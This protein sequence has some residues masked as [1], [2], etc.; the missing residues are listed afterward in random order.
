MF[1]VAFVTTILAT[2]VLATAA[3]AAT[4]DVPDSRPQEYTCPTTT[5]R[6]TR[7]VCC[8]RLV[9]NEAGNILQA[10]CEPYN[11]DLRCDAPGQV[12]CCENVYPAG[13]P[14][15][16]GTSCVHAIPSPARA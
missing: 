11:T 2:A 9:T 10:A 14:P 1:K 7:S 6:P 12:L 5:Y 8:T 13:F 15:L 3:V 16:V 4:P